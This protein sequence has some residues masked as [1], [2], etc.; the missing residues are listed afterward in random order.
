[1][2]QAHDPQLHRTPILLEVKMSS[3][4]NEFER[5]VYTIY[6]ALGNIGGLIG[7]AQI[8]FGVIAGYFGTKMYYHELVNRIMEV[9]VGMRFMGIDG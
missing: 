1:M 4:V 8:V 5:R 3:K 7:L 2:Q 9:E 6:D